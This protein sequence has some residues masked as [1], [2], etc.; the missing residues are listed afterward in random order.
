MQE[1]FTT[2]T[3]VQSLLMLTL[4]MTIGL[5]L[6]EKARI[7]HFSLGV[8][9]VLFVGIIF[10]ACH[11]HI[12]RDVADFAKN[13]GLILFVYS[14]GLQVG[15]AFSPFKKGGLRLN[16]LALG[17]VLLGCVC[18]IVLHYITGID[19]GTMAG[20]MSGAVISTPSLAAVQQAYTDITGQLN[21]DI[22]TG[23]AVAYPMA[24]LGLILAF[25]LIRRF[26]HVSMPQ[27]EQRLRDESRADSEEPICVDITL[28]NPQLEQLNMSELFQ[29]C[30]VKEILVSR[31]IR[32]DGTDELV[33][34]QTMFGN[35]DIL[36]VLTDRK[37][38]DSL[39]LLGEVHNYS[40][41]SKERSVH[42]ISRRIAVTKPECNGKTIR[43]FNL[44]QQYHATITR[45]NRAGIDLLATPDLRLQLGDRLMVVGDKDDVQRVADTFGNELKRLDLPNLLP[46]FFGIVLGIL[47]GLLPIPIPGMSHT[48]KLGLAGGA[49]IVALLIGRFGPYYN[50]VTFATTS[51]NMMLRQVGLTLFMA[52]LGLTA[53]EQFVP[54]ILAGGYVWVAYGF[55]ITIIPVLII[56]SI[57]YKWLRINYF[58][59]IGLM[60]GALT[61]APALGYAESLNSSNDQA[62]VCYAT[63][64]PLTTFMR[65]MLGQLLVLFF[66]S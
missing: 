32:P 26:F 7:G 64:Y 63:V 57:A 19:M 55:L 43:T 3:I 2:P 53:G 58:K 21:P 37:H 46:V 30:P 38:L 60:A 42:L 49:L 27:E 50:M 8:T 51:A 36:R 20:I 61:A 5:W 41:D 66:C 65:V 9:W 24:V 1:F 47:I 39:R 22:A 56:G 18:T 62:S 45:V 34:D 6:S 59:V 15:P 48:F 11:I 35:G 28:N 33:T 25:E 17:I 10:S 44:R 40:F 29:I 54:T 14:I 13:F 4:V 23:Y 52:A 31:V 16:M 12:N